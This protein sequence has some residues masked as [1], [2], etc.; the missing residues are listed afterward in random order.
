MKKKILLVFIILAIV[1]SSAGIVLL[2][3]QKKDN[4]EKQIETSALEQLVPLSESDSVK[5]TTLIKSNIVKVI[6]KLDDNNSIIGTGFFDKSGYLV[7]ASHI[8]D[9]EGTITIQYENGNTDKAQLFSNDITSD[10]ALLTIENPKV[11]ALYFGKTLSVNVTDDV[12]A[13]G[14]P[15]ALEGEASVSKGVLSARRSA[16]GVEFLQSDISLNTG[17]SGGPLISDKGELLGMNVYATDNASIGMSISSESLQSIISNLI[18]S[19]SIN[20]LK[21]ER[22]TNALSVVLTEIGYR[23][24]D[25]YHEK[26]Y[27]KR[28]KEETPDDQNEPKED[29]KIEENNDDNNNKDQNKDNNNNNIS[30]N[31][32]VKKKSSNAYLSSLSIKGYKIDFS[33]GI[34]EYTITLKNNEN[35]LNINAKTADSAATYKI[36]NNSFNEGKN[37]LKIIVTAENGNKMTYVINVIKPLRYLKDANGILCILDVQKYKNVNSL[38]VSGCDFIDSDRIRIDPGVPLDVVQS[39]KIDLYAGWNDGKTSGLDPNKKEIRFLK[40]YTF[41]P[42]YAYGIPLTEIRSMLNDDDYEGGSYAGADLTVHITVNT[43]Q[44]GSFSESKPW[45]LSK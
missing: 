39:V 35:S 22:P 45:G 44:Q 34:T 33:N 24:D 5:A 36:I 1:F 19:K 43:R 7:T 20:Y 13:I 3:Q 15:F 8:V 38:V 18:E 4:P 25:I 29:E 30:D 17:N 6:N 12:Y 40:S 14:Y 10:V 27:F 16:G 23:H 42:A 2:L 21:S 31:Q 9:I 11:K 26:K 28:Y 37:K 32:T 41:S